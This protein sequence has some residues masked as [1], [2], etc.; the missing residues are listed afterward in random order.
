VRVAEKTVELNFCKGFPLVVG[1]DLLWFGLTQKQEAKAGFDACAKS[2]STLMLFQFKAS[3]VVLKNGSRRFLAEH[4]QMQILRDQ[5][6]M[7]RRVYYVLP[8]IGTTAEICGGLCFSHCSR[9]LDVSQLPG[10]IPPPLAKG[11]KPPAVRKNNCH[12]I[13]MAWTLN[14]A[15]VHSD[16]F[17]VNLLSAEDF[18]GASE[19][20]DESRGESRKSGHQRQP[21]EVFGTKPAAGDFGEF[22]S[23]LSRIDRTGL[24]GGY[25]V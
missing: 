16:P 7:N 17:E 12:Y 2:G 18:A 22:W 13:D 23:A 24:L 8:V 3:R 19:G 10:I 20:P 25:A 9:Y 6:K 15:I 14:T 11:V 4:D 5:V 21:G 1:H